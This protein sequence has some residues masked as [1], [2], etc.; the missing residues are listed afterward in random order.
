[1]YAKQDVEG[2]NLNPLKSWQHS[3]NLDIFRYRTISTNPKY[4]FQNMI[5]LIIDLAYAVYWFDTIR[6]M[7]LYLCRVP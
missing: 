7:V 1:M 3:V 6:V 2:N 4:E 5:R